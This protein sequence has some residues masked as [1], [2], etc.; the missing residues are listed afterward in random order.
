VAKGV[1]VNGN[2]MASTTSC[3]ALV[4]THTV[5]ITDMIDSMH[6]SVPI[7]LL[8]DVISSNRDS[9]LLLGSP[10]SLSAAHLP[11]STPLPPMALCAQRL[12]VRSNQQWGF[13]SKCCLSSESPPLQCS[14]RAV[15]VVRGA[16]AAV[17]VASAAGE[18]CRR[19]CW[20]TVVWMGTL[21]WVICPRLEAPKA[22]SIMR[23]CKPTV[24]VRDTQPQMAIQ[25]DTYH[26]TPLSTQIR[27]H[28]SALAIPLVRVG[29]N[30]VTGACLGGQH[31]PCCLVCHAPC[32]TYVSSHSI[33]HHLFTQAHHK[34]INPYIDVVGE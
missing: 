32:G 21:R 20:C 8:G 33:P 11:P 17:V 12:C 13:T 27:S 10:S 30:L 3:P 16:V 7:C 19:C 5:P 31:C 9:A 28:F 29:T 22:A 24:Q 6:V 34:A 25:L 15:G 1:W 18:R 2:C 14:S 23:V 4:A 26:T